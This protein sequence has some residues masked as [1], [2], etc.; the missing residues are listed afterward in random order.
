MSDAQQGH[1]SA[2]PGPEREPEIIDAVVQDAAPRRL[3]LLESA[4]DANGLLRAF[5]R[6]WLLAL[7]VGILLGAAGASSG[8]FMVPPKFTAFAVLR[9]SSGDLSILTRSNDRPSDYVTYQQ[10]QLAMIKSRLVLSAALRELKDAASRDP[11]L[12]DL[13]IMS[14]PDPV[15][16]LEKNLKADFI[17]RSEMLR[18]SL[19]GYEPNEL[20]EL[21]NAITKKYV[22]E[23]TD[24]ERR[25][26]YKRFDELKATKAKYEANLKM[27]KDELKMLG[28]QSGSSRPEMVQLLQEFA[29]MKLEGVEKE[30]VE[31]RT[32]LGRNRQKL[33]TARA[34]AKALDK[35]PAPD[36]QVEAL[37]RHDPEVL[38]QM[39]QVARLESAAARAKEVAT[40]G[41]QSP[42][43]QDYRRQIS[44]LS[45]A[46][47]DRKKFL[48]PQAVE[49][50]R[51]ENRMTVDNS[52]SGLE[53]NIHFLEGW[54]KTCQQDVERLAKESKKR[55]VSS[56]DMEDIREQIAAAEKT[57]KEVSEK[58]EA[59]AIELGAPARIQLID[60]AEAPTVPDWKR[61]YGAT[62][63]GGL[64]GMVAGIFGICMLEF[65]ARR[66]TSSE[67]V[68]QC[69]G[70]RVVGTLPA[71]P[72]P[73]RAR[74]RAAA[75]PYW[76]QVMTDSIDA[77]RTMVLHAASKDGVRVI[78]VASA[79]PG[80]GKTSVASQLSISL[81]RS[82][83]KT[84]L[85]D[86]DLRKPRLHHAF[87]VPAAPG[88][89]EVMRGEAEPMSAANRMPI[90]GFWFMPAGA[91]DEG[92][93][94]ALAQNRLGPVLARLK[95]EFEL[96]IIDTSPVLLVVDP[97]MVAQ[98][99]D[100][101]LFA[102]LRDVSR[103]PK[104]Y[105]A[106]QRLSMLG[107]RMLGAVVSGTSVHGYG[108][109]YGY[110]YYT[111]VHPLGSKR[112]ASSR[113][114]T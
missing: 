105:E 47:A 112:T 106:Y 25:S 111:P 82:G 13:P 75:D 50:W 67:E 108:N 7:T 22:E 100:G 81:G 54:E 104:V 64:L 99:V 96:I 23:V 114:E 16:W 66:V 61:Q 57:Q 97:L 6:R 12:R 18:V 20:K 98:Q 107:V 15:M 109:G 10:T 32:S 8:W 40:Q 110:G 45:A 73:G 53:E 101:V 14:R 71:L 102:V 39:E 83:R 48:R 49:Q 34:R 69:L 11:R 93:I 3:S 36:D 27:K 92:V 41:E 43:V 60:A 80:E 87:S 78:M 4:P 31:V 91:V 9:V 17:Q 1:G 26:R 51:R 37:M 86:G 33:I 30:L 89:S 62:G 44:V 56:S 113:E 42:V 84:L 55:N 76:Q 103:L 90:P 19:S 21:V 35:T 29:M 24:Q 28:Q 46:V 94:Q 70:M 65:R 79:M 77:A 95:E 63:F 85:I 38:K 58:I 72:A 52:I 5:R 68:I 74:A 88:F 59:L 2:Q